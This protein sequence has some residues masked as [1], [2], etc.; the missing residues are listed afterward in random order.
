MNSRSVLVFILSLSYNKFVIKKSKFVKFNE[1][2]GLV[3]I[4][5]LVSF[6][7]IYK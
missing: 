2:L 1:K 6:H 4:K 3:F 5:Y 7:K